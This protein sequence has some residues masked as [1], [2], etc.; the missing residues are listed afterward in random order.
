MFFLHTIITKNKNTL[1]T[2]SYMFLLN[3]AGCSRNCVGIS[4]SLNL[5]FS[6]LVRRST[7]F[8]VKF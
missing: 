5:K 6:L 3:G 8:E 1:R 4:E 7:I 2:F